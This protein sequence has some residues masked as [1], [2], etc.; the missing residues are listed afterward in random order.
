[1]PNRHGVVNESHRYGFNGMEQDAEVKGEGNSYT[2]EFRQYDPRIGRWLSLDPLT[3]SFPWQSPY[4]AF[5]NNPVLLKDPKG[6]AA[7]GGTDPPCGEKIGDSEGD[8]DYITDYGKNV[9]IVSVLAPNGMLYDFGKKDFSYTYSNGE[10]IKGQIKAGGVWSI[11]NSDGNF[12]WNNKTKEYVK[13]TSG[14]GAGENTILGQKLGTTYAGGDNPINYSQPPQNIADAV[15]Y[16]HD[17]EFDELGLV[18]ASGVQ[19]KA[20]TNANNHL[21]RDAAEV[22]RKYVAGEMDRYT[23]APVSYRTYRTALI[24]KKSFEIIESAKSLEKIP[25]EIL[26]AGDEDEWLDA[27]GIPDFNRKL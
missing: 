13:N 26:R 6:L 8:K 10:E 22:M 25:S 21:I 14:R 27:M 1:M 2:T 7:E 3:A 4:V 5:D 17:R 23:G 15:G 20:S 16:R 24:M 11:T 9:D 18:G 19:D 12:L